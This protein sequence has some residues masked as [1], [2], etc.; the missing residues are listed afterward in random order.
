MRAGRRRRTLTL[1]R[2]RRALVAVSSVQLAAQTAGQVVTLR[3]RLHYDFVPLG[4]RGRPENLD[5]D[6]W[7]VGTPMSAPGV[8]FA[9]QAVATAAL[10]SRPSP[11]AARTLG[12]LGWAMIAGYLG[13]RVVQQRLSGRGWDPVETPVAAVGLGGAVVMTVLGLATDVR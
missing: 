4:W 6:V 3:R 8:M 11:L 10:A 5:R 13:E 1:V 7:L 12:F 9:T 2:T